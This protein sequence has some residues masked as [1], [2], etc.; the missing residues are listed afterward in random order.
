MRH[1]ERVSH[2]SDRKREVCVLP[3]ATP[4]Q[5]TKS[6][7]LQ[8]ELLSQQQLHLQIFEDTAVEKTI[9]QF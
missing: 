4:S 3:G 1:S 6:Y 9:N 8:N 2:K 7:T 5:I